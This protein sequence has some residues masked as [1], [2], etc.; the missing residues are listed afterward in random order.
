MSDARSSSSSCS[1]GNRLD[2]GDRRALRSHHRTR[3]RSDDSHSPHSRIP[4][5]IELGSLCFARLT[6]MELLL[7]FPSL[8]GFHGGVGAVAQLVRVPAC[9]AGGCGFDS[10]PPRSIE[11]C[12]RVA[13]ACSF[14]PSSPSHDHRSVVRSPI[15]FH[16]SDATRRRSGRGHHAVVGAGR[17]LIEQPIE[18]C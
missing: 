18:G 3:L 7:L 11:T 9:H 13:G 1:F 2:A 6:V 16:R 4:R 17:H 8:V 10:R 15:G 5:R 14:F 12:P